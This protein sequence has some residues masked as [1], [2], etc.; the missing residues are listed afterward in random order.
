[1]D[2][3]IETMMDEDQGC[4]LSRFSSCLLS[5][6][7]E[8]LVTI[9]S[10]L[11]IDDVELSVKVTCKSLY[12]LSNTQHLWR[13][14]CKQTGKLE[15]S[16]SIKGSYIH[17]R[18]TNIDYKQLYICTP[19]VPLDYP[20]IKQAINFY[21]SVKDRLL[22][23]PFT[24]TLMPGVYNEQIQLDAEDY[25]TLSSV[26]GNNSVRRRG[27]NIRAA[28]HEK[29]AAIVHHNQNDL[30][31]P[32]VS[33]SNRNDYSALENDVDSSVEQS[34]FIFT[35]K[36]IQFLHYT[37]GNDIWNGNCALQVDGQNL[38]VNII[39]CSFQSDSGRGIGKIQSLYIDRMERRA[40]P[41]RSNPHFT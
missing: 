22:G 12:S 20:S 15:E 25:E 18:N 38:H 28:F 11:C 29:G 24:I 13:E 1:M 37:K 2:E 16:G 40:G 31:Q 21:H 26:G 14:F 35:L 10:Y 3:E 8:V 36:D 7:S 27:I 6:P 33:I 39:S 30:N 4:H 9:L 34:T 23:S 5:L 41:H 32:C 19:C 17:Q